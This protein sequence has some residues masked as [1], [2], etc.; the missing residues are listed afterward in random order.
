MDNYIFMNSAHACSY[1]YILMKTTDFFSFP[2]YINRRGFQ[3]QRLTDQY[4]KNSYFLDLITEFN[5]RFK[6]MISKNK[7]KSSLFLSLCFPMELDSKNNYLDL[8]IYKSFFATLKT[9]I[10]IKPSPRDSKLWVCC[11]I[12]IITAKPATVILSLKKSS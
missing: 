12:E 4:T 7:K 5:C 10:N 8:N 6:T 9:R 3:F 2:G 11:Y 1:I